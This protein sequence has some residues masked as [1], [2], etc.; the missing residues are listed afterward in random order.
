MKNKGNLR[1]NE[2]EGVFILFVEWHCTA[3]FIRLCL[4]Y[5]LSLLLFPG[6][7]S[8]GEKGDRTNERGLH[9]VKTKRERK[10]EG[11]WAR[12]KERVKP[13][14]SPREKVKQIS[15]EKK[16][17]KF[18][19]ICLTCVRSYSNVSTF[20]FFPWSPR[21]IFS[22]FLFS[23]YIVTRNFWRLWSSWRKMW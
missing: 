23:L 16:E 4:S 13:L 5:L 22:L 12:E 11:V 7:I 14:S 18:I 10:R 19:F 17:S 1:E 2:C 21:G 3:H 20:S 9:R 15:K 6:Y 8:P